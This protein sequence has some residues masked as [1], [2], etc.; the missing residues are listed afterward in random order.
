[1]CPSFTKVEK[2]QYQYHKNSVSCAAYIS[3]SCECF[4]FKAYEF[5][6]SVYRH[7]ILESVFAGTKDP[8]EKWWIG[9]NSKKE[10]ED[11]NES[12]DHYPAWNITPVSSNYS[13]DDPRSKK[14]PITVYNP[15][16][17][18]AWR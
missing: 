10:M 14:K 16:Q 8:F 6:N 5:F 18:D 3:I 13:V 4:A 1:M 9:L 11:K 7:G 17:A 12:S 2:I 15:H